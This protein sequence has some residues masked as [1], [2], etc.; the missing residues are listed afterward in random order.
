MLNDSLVILKYLFSLLQY[1]A[2]SLIRH[3]LYA[4]FLFGFLRFFNHK[5]LFKLLPPS[6]ANSLKTKLPLE[7][8]DSC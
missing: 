2:V 5:W 8:A 6:I 3:Q 4:D 7:N 1:E